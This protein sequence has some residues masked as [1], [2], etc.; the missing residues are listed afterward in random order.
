MHVPK[1][2]ARPK[3]PKM[4]ARAKD[5]CTSKGA[6]SAPFE[7]GVAQCLC[8]PF[9]TA[10][11]AAEAHDLFEHFGPSWTPCRIDK[12]KRECRQTTGC[13][14]EGL[15]SR[16]ECRQTTSAMHNIESHTTS[17]PQGSLAAKE[18]HLDGWKRVEY[19]NNAVL[20]ERTNVRMM[21]G[22]RL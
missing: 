12:R 20:D 21:M 14:V 17:S 7:L 16:R 10:A 8:T 6:S 15:G 9:R 2:D 19:N 5:R 4:D 18:T 3:V 1:M 11:R 13:R 22:L